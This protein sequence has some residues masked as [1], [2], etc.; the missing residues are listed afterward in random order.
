[1]RVAF[2]PRRLKPQSSV[3]IAAR[4]WNVRRNNQRKGPVSRQLRD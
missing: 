4:P 1:M 2:R 3:A